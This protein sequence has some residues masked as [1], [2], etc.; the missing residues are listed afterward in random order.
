[1]QVHLQ[2][3]VYHMQAA[4]TQA[5]L[6]TQ[7][8]QTAEKLLLKKLKTHILTEEK[9]RRETEKSTKKQAAA[10]ARVE[11]QKA[12]EE[13][14]KQ[15]AS[16]PGKKRAG[17]SKPGRS[18]KRS[19]ASVEVEPTSAAAATVEPAS[20]EKPASGGSASI[21]AGTSHAT[22]LQVISANGT[23]E[24]QHDS[25]PLT[26]H[27]EIESRAKDLEAA[28]A[29]LEDDVPSAQEGHRHSTVDESAEGNGLESSTDESDGE[30]DLDAI[31]GAGGT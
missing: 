1:V 8:R 22:E 31:V 25:V 18:A 3:V 14:R 29:E 2:P 28:A 9:A 6:C 19:K 4:L 11:R 27:A 30:I 16:K 23:Q 13:K 12:A 15:A 10:A 17:S 5:T 26:S 21:G 7:V 20:G 24:V